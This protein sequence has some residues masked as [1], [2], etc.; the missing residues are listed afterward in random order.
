MGSERHTA[1]D[2]AMQAI[3]KGPQ[4]ADRSEGVCG[5]HVGQRAAAGHGPGCP[6]L[7][8]APVWQLCGSTWGWRSDLPGGG[9]PHRFQLLPV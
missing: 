5:S 1:P 7:L 6:L 8:W 2:T 9:G 3:D 4:S